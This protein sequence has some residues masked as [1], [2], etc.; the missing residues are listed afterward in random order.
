MPFIAAF[1][2]VL[3]CA[4]N[5]GFRNFETAD[6]LLYLTCVLDTDVAIVA[7]ITSELVAL[8]AYGKVLWC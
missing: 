4:I 8:S 3:V 5:R 1:V 2:A 6:H 7:S